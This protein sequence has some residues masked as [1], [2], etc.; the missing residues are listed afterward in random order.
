MSRRSLVLAKEDGAVD[1]DDIASTPEPTSTEMRL[2]RAIGKLIT[3]RSDSFVTQQ[4]IYRLL[5]T[6][7]VINIAVVLFLAA[8][9]AMYLRPNGLRDTFYTLKDQFGVAEA[10][11]IQVN[12]TC[13]QLKELL[14]LATVNIPPNLYNVCSCHIMF[15]AFWVFHRS[16][17]TTTAL[18]RV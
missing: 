2:H 6:L 18:Q 14:Y 5:V 11:M 12:T 9:G 13:I 1:Y 4:V 8:L 17:T 7:F 16:Q 3:W 10:I 15:W